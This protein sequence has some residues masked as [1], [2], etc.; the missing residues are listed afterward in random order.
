MIATLIDHG[1]PWG[2]F[3]MGLLIFG[4]LPGF[5]LSL[6]VRLFDSQDPRRDELLAELYAVPR[7][8]RPFW[9]AEQFEVA[10]REVTFP[11]LWWWWGRLIWHRAT[12]ESGVESNQAYPDSF[13]IPDADEKADLRPGDRVKLMWSVRGLPGERMW[14]E[15]LERGG[16]QFVGH[17]RNHPMFVHLSCGEQVRFHADHIIDW[18]EPHED[19]PDTGGAHDEGRPHDGRPVES[20][21]THQ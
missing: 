10:T 14:V 7:W 11:F 20:S 3:V 17:L 15:I 21:G 5:V 8:E 6:I 18:Y 9:V 4:F 13:E 12:L 2:L 1:V 19:E 16:D